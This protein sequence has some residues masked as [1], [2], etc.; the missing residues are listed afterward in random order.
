MSEPIEIVSAVTGKPKQRRVAIL[1]RDDGNLPHAPVA[2]APSLCAFAMRP[3][4]PCL[5]ANA[6]LDHVSLGVTAINRSRRF[7][8]AMLR[9]LGVVRIVDFGESRGSDYGASPGGARR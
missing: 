4:R 1:Q 7:Y 9:P 3:P 5:R 6:M 2:E 8:D